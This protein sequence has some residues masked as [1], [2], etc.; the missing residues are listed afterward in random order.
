[1]CTAPQ[2]PDEPFATLL[3]TPASSRAVRACRRR[4]AVPSEAAL[5]PLPPFPHLL[6][7]RPFRHHRHHLALRPPFVL[8]PTRTLPLRERHPPRPVAVLPH[9]GLRPR[10]LHA[11]NLPAS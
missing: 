7:R 3:H 6:V 5:R 9:T 2:A 11:G 4:C 1:D 10:F 8:P